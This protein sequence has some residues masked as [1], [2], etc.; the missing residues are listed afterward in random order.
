[1]FIVVFKVHYFSL[2]RCHCRVKYATLLV[3]KRMTKENLETKG[4]MKDATCMF[5]NIELEYIL[6]LYGLAFDF[7]ILI[8]TA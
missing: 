4:I 8:S 3:P 7:S 1:M 2:V 6:S 5:I